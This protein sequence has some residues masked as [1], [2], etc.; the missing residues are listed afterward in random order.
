MGAALYNVASLG[1]SFVALV[2]SAI[3]AW[4]QLRHARSQSALTTILEVYFRDIR[5]M[6]FQR[7]QTYV[8]TRLAT[9]HPAPDEGG[10]AALPEQAQHAIWNVAFMYESIGMMH[11]LDMMDSRVALGV[12]NFRIIQVWEAMEPYIMAERAMRQA[13]FLAFFE[14]LYLQARATPPA[15]L[16]RELGLRTIGGFTPRSG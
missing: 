11:A 3:A 4:R 1:V 7:D 15:D 9:E 8:V 12:F 2:L 6:D 10:I 14:N 5:D 13:P 16:Y